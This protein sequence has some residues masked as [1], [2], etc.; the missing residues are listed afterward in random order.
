MLLELTKQLVNVS[1]VRWLS[2]FEGLQL[3]GSKSDIAQQ[4]MNAETVWHLFGQSVARTEA[5]SPSRSFW[6]AWTAVSASRDWV[7]CIS[8]IHCN[9]HVP[10]HSYYANLTVTMLVLWFFGYPEVPH[11]W[12]VFC[13]LKFIVY[14]CLTFKF[15]NVEAKNGV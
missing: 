15:Y 2:S 11:S 5:F 7:D 9:S 14:Y 4:R 6:L 13:L 12:Q 3:L 8:W 1:A 10:Y